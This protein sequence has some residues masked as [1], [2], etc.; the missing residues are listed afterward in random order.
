MIGLAPSPNA[1]PAW[2]VSMRVG[3]LWH[4]KEALRDD[5]DMARAAPG[6]VAPVG[7]HQTLTSGRMHLPAWQLPAWMEAP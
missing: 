5:D 6:R 1:S 7:L 4:R 3:R 2:L